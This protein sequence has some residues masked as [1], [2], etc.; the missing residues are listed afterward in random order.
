MW[1]VTVR[2]H[3]FPCLPG[4]MAQH[5]SWLFSPLNFTQAAKYQKEL[6]GPFSFPLTYLRR[7]LEV[8]GVA[9]ADKQPGK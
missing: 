1:A 9:F 6:L 7:G 5:S 4:F 2:R 8:P 3:V